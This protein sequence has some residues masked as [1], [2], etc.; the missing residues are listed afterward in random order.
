MWVRQGHRALQDRASKAARDEPDQCRSGV[1]VRDSPGGWRASLDEATRVRL[2][3]AVLSAE[4]PYR[5][6]AAPLDGQPAV[7]P[8]SALPEAAKD[9]LH[10]PVERASL[11]AALASTGGKLGA[12]AECR[13]PFQ[14]LNRN[15]RPDGRRQ[16]RASTAELWAHSRLPREEAGA[17]PRGSVLV[18]AQAQAW[19]ESPSPA[20]PRP[21]AERRVALTR[22]AAAAALWS[23]AVVRALQQPPSVRVPL[24][25]RA[26]PLGV[27]VSQ[28]AE[29]AQAP[30]SAQLPRQLGWAPRLQIRPL[31][32]NGGG[33]EALR[34]HPESWSAFSYQ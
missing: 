27:R 28:R 23:V 19:L 7:L 20:L 22:A 10:P 30:A 3:P 26:L 33:S 2:E 25:V 4:P 29:R 12:A 9:H 11:P 14:A 13:E 32:P 31:R 15:P 6:A 1:Q 34:H 8:G 21:L 5:A 18:S 16:A 17:D 24:V